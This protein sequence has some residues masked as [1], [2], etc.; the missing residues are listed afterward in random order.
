MNYI[1]NCIRGKATEKDF[2]RYVNEW[3]M[4]TTGKR[5]PEF[6]GMTESAYQTIMQYNP[7]EQREQAIRQ[8]INTYR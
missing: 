4:T 2:D 1:Q 6:L 8:V 5:L 3:L 7:G